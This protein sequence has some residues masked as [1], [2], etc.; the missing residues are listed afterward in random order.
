[1]NSLAHRND[2]LLLSP[3]PNYAISHYPH[4]HPYLHALIFLDRLLALTPIITLTT[5]FPVSFASPILLPFTGY[6]FV[7]RWLEFSP[8]Y[9]DDVMLRKNNVAIRNEIA[10][11]TPANARYFKVNFSGD[12]KKFSFFRKKKIS[13]IFAE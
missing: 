9:E 7:F 1:M 2:A 3:S 8:S 6:Q 12:A 4:S 13:V 11:T 5:P 10:H